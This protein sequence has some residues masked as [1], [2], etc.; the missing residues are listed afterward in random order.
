MLLY[1][2]S[3][4]DPNSVCLLHDLLNLEQFQKG[5]V[6]STRRRDAQL[7]ASTRRASGSAGAFFLDSKADS[8]PLKAD[9]APRSLP[10]RG[11]L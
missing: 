1:M 10:T 3:K 4:I 11:I 5:R 9:P 7:T 6:P 2:H 8:A